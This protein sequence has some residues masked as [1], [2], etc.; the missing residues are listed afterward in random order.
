[1]SSEKREWNRLPARGVCWI[2][3]D[4]PPDVAFPLT[5]ALSLGEREHRRQGLGES[6]AS[7]MFEQRAAWLPLPEGEGRGEGEQASPSSSLLHKA[8]SPFHRA[9]SWRCE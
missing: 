3:H 9:F 8:N 4:S 2:G 1:M 6:T 5:P 7:G